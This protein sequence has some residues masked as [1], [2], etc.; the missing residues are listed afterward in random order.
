M[1]KNSNAKVSADG[2]TYDGQLYTFKEMNHKKV[3]DQ[4][5]IDCSPA[6]PIKMI[7]T[8]RSTVYD[9]SQ[10]PTSKPHP[11]EKIELQPEIMDT[12]TD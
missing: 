3:W 6:E 9:D 11:E 7:G 5:Q 2:R 8:A 4:L 1:K 12:P 10:P